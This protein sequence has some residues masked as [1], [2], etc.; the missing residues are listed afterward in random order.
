MDGWCI[1]KA[2]GLQASASYPIHQ[3]ARDVTIHFGLDHL[4]NS[5]VGKNTLH[6]RKSRQALKLVARAINKTSMD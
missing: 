3:S 5:V 4:F 6:I 2:E 1:L